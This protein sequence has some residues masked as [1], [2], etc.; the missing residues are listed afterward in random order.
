MLM[1]MQAAF[2]ADTLS[3]EACIERFKKTREEAVFNCLLNRY[4]KSI[5]RI[6][7][8]IVPGITEEDSEDIIQETALALYKALPDFSIRSSFSTYLYRL[9]R[10]KAVDHIRKKQKERRLS[11]RILQNTPD[12]TI[13]TPEMITEKKETWNKVTETLSRLPEIERTLIILKDVEHRKLEEISSILKKPV[14]TV[15]SRL[16]R[17]RIHAA[18]IFKEEKEAGGI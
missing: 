17:A 13:N 12:E 5:R 3:D 7:Y 8:S 1:E 16:H 4:I 18:E 11:R 15:K 14:G 2:S 6:I 10:N 9:C